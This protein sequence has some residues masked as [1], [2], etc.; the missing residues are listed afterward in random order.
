MMKIEE[1][2]TMPRR[3]FSL[4][5]LFLLPLICTA[6]LW[7]G[8]GDKSVHETVMPT[9][10]PA[11]IRL[12][13]QPCPAAAQKPALWASIITPASDQHVERVLCGNLMGVSALQAVVLVVHDDYAALLDLYVYT[14]IT[15]AHPSSVLTLKGLMHGDARISNYNTLLTAQE[16]PNSRVNAGLTRQWTVD[17]Y[18]EY[19]W[20]DTAGTLMQVA[21]AG[22]F[23][24]LTRYQADVAQED[25]NSGQNMQQWRLSVVT[26]VQHFVNTLLHWPADTPVTVVSGGGLHDIHAVAQVQSAVPGSV[27]VMVS[28]D[29]LELNA[30]GGIWEIVHVATKGLTL[31]V[32]QSL[33]MLVS[34]AKVTGNIQAANGMA[35]T[36]TVWDHWYTDSGHAT[37]AG[38]PQF[39]IVLP[40]TLTFPN[41]TQEGLMALTSTTSDL[42]ISGIV[43]AKVLLRA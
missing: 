41:A 30:N 24:D 16:D 20:S 10:T 28:L 6:C 25:V 26:T 36:I 14:N 7:N 15:S 27:P 19:K 32:P 22:M 9:P 42:T 13:V 8:N 18:R 1:K 31:D 33:P 23:P 29:R 34:P 5:T 35:D 12:G 43:L 21:F 37:L 40:Y 39:S 2:E 38:S 11:P 3:F 4:A 17:L